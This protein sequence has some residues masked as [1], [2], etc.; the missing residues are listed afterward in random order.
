LETRGIAS[1]SETRGIA[2]LRVILF[3]VMVG[4]L[5]Y[6]QGNLGIELRPKTYVGNYNLSCNGGN[7][8]EID[9]LITGGTAPYTLVWNNNSTAN[10]LL[11]LTAGTYSI[12]VTDAAN[13]TAQASVTL[14]EPPALGYNLEVSQFGEYNLQYFG[15]T[16]GTIKINSSG[17][18]PSYQ[19]V[20]GDNN[21]ELI[22]DSLAA[23]T[24]SFVLTDANGCSLSG[25]KTLTQPAVLSGTATQLQAV[26]CFEGED[27]R[28]QI[29]ASGGIAPYHY[30]WDNG[31]FSATPEDLRAGVHEVHITDDAD[32]TLTLQVT[33]TEPTAIDVQISK[34]N[35][36]NNFNVS[37]YNCFNGTI[38]AVASGGTAPYTF[39]WIW[40][41]NSIGTT[42]NLSNLG[43]GDY[44]LIINDQ[45]NCRYRGEVNLK[46]PER[47][48]W[49]MSGNAGTDPAT[50]F[51]GTTDSVD[52]V[53]RSNNAEIL[54][55]NPD[56][57]DFN[58][59]IELANGHGLV[60]VTSQNNAKWTLFKNPIS[61]LPDVENR[62]CLADVNINDGWDFEGWIRSHS[63]TNSTFLYM[64]A[65]PDNGIIEV[66]KTTGNSPSRLHLNN[67]C[68]KDVLIGNSISGNLLL[69]NK[70]G[71]GVLGP[72]NS[73]HIRSDSESSQ[74][75]LV[76]ANGYS[77][78]KTISLL[79][80]GSYLTLR[81]N[82]ATIAES[83]IGYKGRLVFMDEGT[84]VMDFQNGNVGIGISPDP[85]HKLS[86]C[87]GGIRS[88]YVI[89]T[90]T[91]CDYVFKPDYKLM[92]LSSLEQYVKKEHHLP[93]VP[94]ET[95][96]ILSG[97]NLGQI[98]KIQMEKIEELYLYLFQLK[99]E[100]EELKKR[101]H[102]IEKK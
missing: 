63:E 58:K 3:M 24:Y 61:S 21:T 99:E 47:Q 85:N 12:T 36:P 93:N 41:E 102:Q 17:G 5:S 84:N 91:W 18:T 15:S 14:I 73:L 75:I 43:G 96:I 39:E 2:S 9:V 23:G 89:V 67:Y 53:F 4:N 22:R 82:N 90:E 7:N 101:L 95:E 45:N 72:T 94:P 32:N 1:F 86:V 8:G 11:N 87:G 33:I 42:A 19:V 50:Q 97:L 76:E 35:Y 69:Y 51:I 10:P 26:R 79:P 27:G 100:N 13:A 28:A 64:G 70:I 44:N 92:P 46:E 59:K 55:I 88:N 71:I 6:A 20:W 83:I 77:E 31:S 38:D 98:Q 16:L 80:E 34:S 49:G 62:Y 66:V 29:T 74:H 40:Q 78:I 25:S 56:R 81:A 68:G 48:D 52:V 30:L 60:S 37:C 65:D 57:A 54:R